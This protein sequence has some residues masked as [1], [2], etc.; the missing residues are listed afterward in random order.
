MHVTDTW[1]SIGGMSTTYGRNLLRLIGEV[2][3][4]NARG[5]PSQTAFAERVG[6]P[7]SRINGH[8]TGRHKWIRPDIE[9]RIL[10]AL[11]EAAKERGSTKV[12][13]RDDLYVGVTTHQPTSGKYPR[14]SSNNQLAHISQEVHISVAKPDNNEPLGALRGPT[15]N[16]DTPR[17][18]HPPHDSVA[19]G[20]VLMERGRTIQKYGQE[21][22]AFGASL[23]AGQTAI[24]AVERPRRRATDDRSSRRADGSAAGE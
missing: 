9:A 7:V 21:L 5:K 17:A 12:Y 1:A 24:F 16:A 23:I 19:F 13:T 22:E 8:I 11:T 18:F 15:P 20:H 10:E 14:L 4:L 3:L 2:G 6:W